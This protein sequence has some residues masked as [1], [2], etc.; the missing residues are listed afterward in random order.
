[1][2][3]RKKPTRS[4]LRRNCDDRVRKIVVAHG[5]CERCGWTA[6]PFEAAHVI[7]RRYSWTR[8]DERNLWCLCRPCHQTIDTYVSA[9]NA[10]VEA[11]IGWD[12]HAELEEK[13]RKREKFDWSAE[14]E[15]LKALA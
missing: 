2:T 14:L 6:G 15:R 1:M 4:N 12:L 11:T 8:T 5:E 7:R 3:A 10:L 9:F 13:S